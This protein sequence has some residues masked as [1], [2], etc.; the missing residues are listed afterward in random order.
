MTEL[1]LDDN[2]EPVDLSTA[3]MKCVSGNWLVQLYEHLEANPQIVVHGF[4]HAGIFSAL[5]LIDEDDDLPEYPT[6]DDDDDENEESDTDIDFDM[7]EEKRRVLSVSDVFS[8]DSEEDTVGDL[9]SDSLIVIDSD[10]ETEA[11]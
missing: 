9:T 4:R 6:S 5:S 1:F 3:R 7:P 8:S 11:K 10:T 2:D